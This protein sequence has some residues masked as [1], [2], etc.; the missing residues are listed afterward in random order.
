VSELVGFLEQITVRLDSAGIPYMVSGSMASSAW[1][2]PRASYDIDI[3]IDPSPEQ[4][5]AFVASLDDEFYVNAEAAEEA[6][7]TRGIFNVIDATGGMKAD[8][9]MRK[10]RPFSIEEFGRRRPRR[11]SEF[12]F[13]VLSPEDSILSKLEWSKKGDSAR[14]FD[15]ALRVARLRRDELDVEYLRRWAKELGVSEALERLLEE[16]EPQEDGHS[17]PS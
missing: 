7:Q 3:V 2:E 17:C 6:L 10:E 14:Q 15:D 11:M 12:R 8:L 1:G 5:R 4:L 9:I 16:T 13:M